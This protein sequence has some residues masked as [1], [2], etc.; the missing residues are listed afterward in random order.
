V[1]YIREVEADGVQA[2]TSASCLKIE[3]K[4]TY[5]RPVIKINSGPYKGNLLRTGPL[6]LL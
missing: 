5:L 3:T 2:G 4:P 6:Y 1:Q